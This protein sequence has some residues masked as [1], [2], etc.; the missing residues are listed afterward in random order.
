MPLMLGGIDSLS[1]RSVNF[2]V[3]LF[4]ESAGKFVNVANNRHTRDVSHNVERVINPN[5]LLR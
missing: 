5:K 4:L 1:L 3:D 2:H